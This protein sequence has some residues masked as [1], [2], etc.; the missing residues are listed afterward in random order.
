ML[1]TSASRADSGSGSRMARHSRKRPLT[2]WA[3]ASATASARAARGVASSNSK[4]SPIG[5]IER[6]DAN[7]QHGA[8]A[9]T[10]FAQGDCIR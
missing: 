8:M 1:S 6:F 9:L 2:K 4:A 5:A 3:R 10:P 7:Q